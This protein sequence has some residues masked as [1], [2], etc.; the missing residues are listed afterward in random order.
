MVYSDMQSI[1]HYV[2]F[3]KKCNISNSDEKKYI[4]QMSAIDIYVQL[5]IDVCLFDCAHTVST[6]G[7][8]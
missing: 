3:R 1:S 5:L 4:S 7:F 6:G 8:L 2:Q